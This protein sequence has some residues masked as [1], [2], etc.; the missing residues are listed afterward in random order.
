MSTSPP[1]ELC[2]CGFRA[3]AAWSAPV[4]ACWEKDRS[5]G[6]TLLELITVVAIVAVLVSLAF[7]LAAMIRGEGDRVKCA[8]NL[9]QVGTGLLSFSMDH[10]NRLPGPLLG[11]V[12]PWWS[13]EPKALS[14]WIWSYVN[15]ETSFKKPRED[16]LMCPSY[17]R[18]VKGDYTSIPVF[19]LNTAAKMRGDLETD[20]QPFG[21]PHPY[22]NGRPV[23]DREPL[24]VPQLA[25][26]T[27]ATGTGG[28]AIVWA[29]KDADAC[30]PVFRNSSFF[31]R[32]PREPRHRGSRNALF[33][34]FHVGG[35]DI[36]DRPVR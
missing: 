11:A 25:D 7:P 3:L 6:F 29:L 21:Y 14:W 4:H 19:T 9:R 27:D 28:P 15:I 5:P 36:A 1:G 32:L 18:D 26:L 13:N 22:L 10:D 30:D 31:K 34:D 12:F 23:A 20:R 16:V 8:S 2:I 33:F 24:R 35:V 17:K